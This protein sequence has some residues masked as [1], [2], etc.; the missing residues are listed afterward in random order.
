MLFNK[1]YGVRVPVQ[2]QAG[3]QTLKN[4]IPHANVIPCLAASMRREGL[5]LL[6][7]DGAL[8]HRIADPRHKLQK[9]IWCKSKACLLKRARPMRQ[10]RVLG[11]SR[12]KPA[13]ARSP[14]SFLVVAAHAA[15]PRASRDSTAWLELRL[16]EGKNRQVRQHDGRS[17]A[18]DAASHPLLRHDWTIEG[19]APG[20]GARSKS[21]S[22]IQASAAGTVLWWPLSL[23]WHL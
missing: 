22:C 18:A 13:A 5:V 11:R 17:R 10:G 9:N 2:P 21:V 19:L 1:P 7:A 16:H 8:Q 15:D 6:T 4:F 12:R 14:T 3:R 20:S 23:L